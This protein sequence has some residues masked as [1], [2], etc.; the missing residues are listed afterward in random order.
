MGTGN[1]VC[2]SQTPVQLLEHG[3][4]VGTALTAPDPL[5][6]GSLSQGVEYCSDRHA[7]LLGMRR[8]EFQVW[9]MKV[10]AEWTCDGIVSL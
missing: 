1:V 8:V 3:Q 7:P 10:L 9:D 2:R 5:G 6:N 4:H